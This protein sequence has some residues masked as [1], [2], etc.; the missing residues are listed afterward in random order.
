MYYELYIDSMLL[1]H[2]VMNLFC[3]CLVNLILMRTATRMRLILGAMIGA[4]TYLIPFFLPGTGFLKAAVC[5]PV[6]VA[7]MVVVAFRPACGKAVFHVAGLLLGVSFLLGGALLFFLEILPE[8]W[9]DGVLGIM[10]A[11]ALVFTEAARMIKRSGHTGL[12]KVELIGKGARIKVNALLDTGN[13]LIEPVS[14]KPVCVLEKSVFEGLWRTGK[15][16]GFRVIPYHSVGKKQG[17]LYGF[18]L[19]EI[20]INNNGLVKNCKDIYVGV[21]DGE[22][23]QSGGYCMIL[24]PAL[25]LTEEAR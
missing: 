11:G 19:P 2:F 9:M 18:L 17:V 5:L 22:I 20:R 23:A 3:L 14:G 6:S 8:R 7:A 13:G 12:C 16:E 1:L 15:P 21:V 25:L 10:G 24:N 4:F